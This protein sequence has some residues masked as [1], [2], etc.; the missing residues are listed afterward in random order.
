MRHSIQVSALAL[1]TALATSA[2][3]ADATAPAKDASTE[4]R[5]VIVT[6]TKRSE[7][8]QRVPL[9]IT[10]FGEQTL[11]DSG[12]AGLQDYAAAVPNLA[13]AYT[14]FLGA[15]GQRITI[16]GIYGANTTGVYVDDTPLPES[17]DPRVLDLSR[18]EVLRG[19]QGTLYGARSEGGTVRL[20]TNQPDAT[21]FAASLHAVG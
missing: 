6:A 18:I 11:K 13:I 9:S 16:R 2:E 5:E 1:L 8:I 17:V 14:G 3:A 12:V 10:A 7:S 21:R 15:T 4:V 19:P 20:I